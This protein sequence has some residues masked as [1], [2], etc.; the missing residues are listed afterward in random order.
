MAEES[1]DAKC[2]CHYL[3]HAISVVVVGAS[4]D[5]AK[6]K[7]KQRKGQGHCKLAVYSRA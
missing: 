1:P 4:G 3:D 6:K 5:L 7:V 2:D